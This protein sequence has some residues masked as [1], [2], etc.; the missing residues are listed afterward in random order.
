MVGGRHR[1]IKEGEY[2]CGRKFG[3]T[4][5]VESIKV[6]KLQ[7]VAATKNFLSILRSGDRMLE[8][9]LSN[10]EPLL[11]WEWWAWPFMV[12]LKVW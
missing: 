12:F 10:H 2:K 3:K 6:E 7:V 5:A 4:S 11:S 1:S 9:T 8:E